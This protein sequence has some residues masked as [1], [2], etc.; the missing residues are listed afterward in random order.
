MH[1]PLGDDPLSPERGRFV[2]ESH[3]QTGRALNA[4]LLF[5]LGGALLVLAELPSH[6]ALDVFAWEQPETPALLFSLA[7]TFLHLAGVVSAPAA[8]YLIDRIGVRLTILAGMGIGGGGLILYGLAQSLRLLFPAYALIGAGQTMGG[9]LPVMVAVCRRFHRRRAMAIA[10]TMTVG[11]LGKAIPLVAL[12]TL[13]MLAAHPDSGWISVDML[14]LALGAVLLVVA[15]PAYALVRRRRAEANL[16]TGGEGPGDDA[17]AELPPAPAEPDFTARQSLRTRAFRLIVAGDALATLSSYSILFYLALWMSDEGY[18]LA[19]GAWALGLNLLISTCFILMGGFVG[20]RY[21]LRKAL[22][23]FTVLQSAGIALLAFAD[24]LG[25][26]LLAVSV[27]GIG[28]G[29]S[30]LSVAIQAN[31]FGTTSLGKILGWHIMTVSLM[32]FIAPVLTGVILDLLGDNSMPIMFLVLAVLGLLGAL[33]FLL[34][35]QPSLPEAAP[36]PLW[37]PSS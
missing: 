18:S 36:A 35:R 12:G 8:G 27:V 10:I 30:P 9:W 17:A 33:C 11:E 7:V 20:N 28:G 3:R 1:Y 21:S 25:L 24:S 5:A 32:T 6:L 16:P 29:N 15:I 26:V 23:V 22:A 19:S 31:Y 37:A 34:A 4:L 14:L 13:L 2:R